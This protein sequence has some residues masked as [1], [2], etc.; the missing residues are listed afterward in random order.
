MYLHD[1]DLIKALSKCRANLTRKNGKTGLIFIKENVKRGGALLDKSDNSIA[2]SEIFFKVIFDTC[3]LK[4]IH[5]TY[6]PDWDP[7]LMPI[8]LW[9]LKP[10]EPIQKITRQINQNK[11]AI[12]QKICEKMVRVE[13]ADGR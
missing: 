12:S 2:R 13:I 7:D 10:L 6:Q 3:G 5:K 4:I 9:V 1:R 11:F 8:C